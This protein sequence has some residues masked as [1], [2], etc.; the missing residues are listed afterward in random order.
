MKKRIRI[1]FCVLLFALFAVTILMSWNSQNGFAK[2]LDLPTQT[3]RLNSMDY[4]LLYDYTDIDLWSFTQPVYKVKEYNPYDAYYIL[5][6]SQSVVVDLDAC[7]GISSG[8]I[9]VKDPEKVPKTLHSEKICAVSLSEAFSKIHIPLDLTNEEIQV[10]EKLVFPDDYCPPL[11]EQPEFCLD[12]DNDLPKQRYVNFHID[13][14]K[15]LYYYRLA[16]AK[17]TNGDYYIMHSY[18]G[19]EAKV[20]EN[21]ALKIDKAF[22]EQ[23]VQF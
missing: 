11:K 3:E 12:S 13:G 16:L 10:L 14:L 21:I 1:C 5:D 6:D 4:R 22:Q 7:I 15:G 20:P 8:K 9:Y 2:T 18:E 19:A 17:A 23:S